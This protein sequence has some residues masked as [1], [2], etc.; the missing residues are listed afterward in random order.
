MKEPHRRKTHRQKL[1]KRG[2]VLA[3]GMR[4]IASLP[5]IEFTYTEAFGSGLKEYARAFLAWLNLK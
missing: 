2:I 1:S 4:R 3:V 5:P